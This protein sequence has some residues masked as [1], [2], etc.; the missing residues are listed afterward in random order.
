MPITH[1]LGGVNEVQAWLGKSMVLLRRFEDQAQ[2]ES[3]EKKVSPV[4]GQV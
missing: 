1:G 2:P 3:A 4:P